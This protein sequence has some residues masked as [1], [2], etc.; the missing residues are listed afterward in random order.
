MTP[1]GSCNRGQSIAHQIDVRSKLRPRQGG[2]GLQSSRGQLRIGRRLCQIQRASIGIDLRSDET[3]FAT[4]IPD[5][6]TFARRP[7]ADTHRLIDIQ[8]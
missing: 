5:Q 8:S 2:A 6:S 1:T 7:V 3:K 4:Q